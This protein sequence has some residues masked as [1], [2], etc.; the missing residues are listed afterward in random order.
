MLDTLL[1][2]I[3]LSS[4]TY[5]L[6]DDH[7]HQI[8]NNTQSS[9]T[10]INHV[11]KWGFSFIGVTLGF[12]AVF[13]APLLFTCIKKEKI[14]KMLPWLTC[15][16]S[17]AILA[18][19]VNHNLSEITHQISFDWKVGSVFLSGIICNYIAVYG[20]TTDDHCCEIEDDCESQQHQKE[21]CEEKEHEHK[22]IKNNTN[23]VANKHSTRHW[24]IPVLFGDAFCNFSDGLLI[25]SSFM[26]CGNSFGWLATLVVVIHEILHEIGDFS[27]IISNGI[28][29]KKAVLYNMIS[30][31]TTYIA[32]IIVN[33]I[34]YLQDAITINS[35]LVTFGSGV[36][37]SLV[38]TLVPKFIKDKSLKIQRL[39][40]LTIIIGIVVSTAIFSWHPE[41]E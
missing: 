25:T 8:V 31:S 6:E 36:L 23:T 39:R 13:V 19:I 21:C 17:G 9:V 33:S 10:N 1:I 20:F 27:I 26:L 7:N 40:I 41:C 14:F 35:Y 16:G 11:E 18:L 38:L 32:W 34:S 37:I 24:T 4:F 2:F 5:G 3:L 22:K 29:F 15:F 12:M 30:A 28:E